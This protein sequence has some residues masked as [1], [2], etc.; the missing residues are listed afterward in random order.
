MTE[1]I[2]RYSVK[3]SRERNDAIKKAA[4][5]AGMSEGLYIQTLFDRIDLAPI[6]PSGKPLSKYDKPLTLGLVMEASVE[7]GVTESTARVL[8]VMRRMSD[9]NGLLSM[10][11][12]EIAQSAGMHISTVN[13]SMHQLTV[14]GLVKHERKGHGYSKA[15]IRLID[16]MQVA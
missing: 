13:S 14:K 12:E 2:F 3:C 4:R 9:E 10:S 15:I 7:Y 11:R 6:A 8:L 5:N 16:Q 1:D